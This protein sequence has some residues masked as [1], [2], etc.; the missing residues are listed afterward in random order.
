MMQNT[1]STIHQSKLLLGLPM[2]F[3]GKRSR[4]IKTEKK[5]SFSRF[6]SSVF[7]CKDIFFKVVE[8]DTMPI[9][10]PEVINKSRHTLMTVLS[11]CVKSEFIIGMNHCPLNNYINTNINQTHVYQYTLQS[12]EKIICNL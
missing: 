8:F 7:S 11:I 1:E 10:F 3:L 4:G 6:I 9:S 2:C 12:L 5:L